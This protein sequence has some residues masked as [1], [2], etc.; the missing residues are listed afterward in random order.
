M[1]YI[2]LEQLQDDLLNFN[3]LINCTLKKRNS[4]L[5]SSTFFSVQ[6]S[7]EDD[8]YCTLDL[9]FTVKY[10]NVQ[11]NTLR[12]RQRINKYDYNIMRLLFFNFKCDIMKCLLFTE[13]FEDIANNGINVIRGVDIRTE[14]FESIP[15]VKSEL[16][17]KI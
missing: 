3:K 10:K 8:D 17:Q 12:T 13:T 7:S 9:I 5:E 16:D 15:F 6:R 2:E 11:L 1:D 4:K 14:D